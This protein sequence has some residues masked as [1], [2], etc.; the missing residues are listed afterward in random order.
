MR[1]LLTIAGL[2]EFVTEFPVDAKVEPVPVLVAGLT[3]DFC[4]LEDDL[5]G[6]EQ[7]HGDD[8]EPQEPSL[9]PVTEP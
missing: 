4:P 6:H 5:E 1:V 2:F 9:P 3:A 8:A 7:I